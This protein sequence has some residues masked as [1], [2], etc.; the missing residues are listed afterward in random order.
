ML[1]QKVLELIHPDDHALIRF[2]LGRITS[3]MLSGGF[4][5]YRLRADPNA[6]GIL[7]TSSDITEQQAQLRQLHDAAYRDALTGLPNRAQVNDR[8][9][10]LVAGNASLA[11]AFVRIDR[12]TL[13]N[14]SLGHT[15]GDAVLQAV[16]ARVV[17]SVPTTMMVGKCEETFLSSTYADSSARG[18]WI[19]RS[20]VCES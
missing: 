10:E 13:I 17:S 3:G 20:D 5:T 1:G 9:D 11:V 18:T 12:F 19:S 4:T 16:S 7:V 14:D 15:M 6:R 2:E 8:L